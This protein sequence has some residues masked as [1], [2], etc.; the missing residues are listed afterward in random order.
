MIEK[1]VL[2]GGCF[3]CL[4]A[5]YQLVKGV[6]EVTPGYAG[7]TSRNPS[8]WGIHENQTGH[9]EVV[10]ISFDSTKISYGDI[11]DIFW[12]IHDPT[13]PNR[14]GSDIGPEYRSIILYDGEEQKKISEASK[15]AIQKLWDKPVI[16]EIKPLKKFY[17]A[18]PEH[19]DFYKKHPDMAYC[20]VIINPKLEKLKT[21]FATQLK[22]P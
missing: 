9:A 17:E 14:Q 6:R 22:Q 21:K 2:G 3:W 8:Y 4:E 13:T 16:T 11:L 7:G 18:E 15:A 12:V 19:H 10:Q 20:Q 5:S 1:A